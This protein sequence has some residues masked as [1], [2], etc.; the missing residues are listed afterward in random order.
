MNHS[1]ENTSLQNVSV[2]NLQV[3][4]VVPILIVIQ[5]D[6]G[7]KLYTLGKLTLRGIRNADPIDLQVVWTS[8]AM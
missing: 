7:S 1:C 5:T 8:I 2:E 3:S 4:G 6:I